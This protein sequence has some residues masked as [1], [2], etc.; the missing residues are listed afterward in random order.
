VILT[1]RLAALALAASVVVGLTVRSWSGLA[2]V[3]GIVV[4]LAIIDAVLAGSTRSLSIRR[5]GAESTRLGEPIEVSLTVRNIGRRRVRGVVRDAWV[6]S[7]GASPTRQWIDIEP[8]AAQRI[9]TVLNPWRRGSRW[10]DR[11]TVRSFG[12]MKL[13]GRQGS[14]LVPWVVTVHPGFPSRRHLP[15]RLA[16]LRE[17]DGRSAVNVRGQGT[18]FD[19]LREYVIGDDIRSIDWRASARSRDTIVKTWRPERDRRIVLVIDSGRTSAAR[20]GDG[21]RL[22]ATMDAALLLGALASRAGDRID[23]IAHDRDVRISLRSLSAGDVLP[24]M[25]AALTPLEPQLVET[26]ARSMVSAVLT[27]VRQRSLVVLLTA[28]DPAAVEENL[29]DVLPLLVARHRVIIAAVSDPRLVELSQSRATVS[30]IYQAAS[31][32]AAQ[33]RRR[34]LVARLTRMGVDVVDEVPERLAVAL[35]DRYLALKAAGRL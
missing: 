13:A 21:T 19:S 18:E 31:A 25:S 29:L 30:E 8:V 11:I 22:D 6:P 2:L 9:T 5:S 23:L 17:I 26:N 34:E 33:Q 15:S 32:L 12:P 3:N 27:R 20:I 7:A 16:R 4:A 10:A 24:A 1:G 35:S 14:H 28:L